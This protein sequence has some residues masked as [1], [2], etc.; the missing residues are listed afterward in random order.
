M[1]IDQLPWSTLKTEILNKP[2]LA[3]C[4]LPGLLNDVQPSRLSGHWTGCE[5]SEASEHNPRSLRAEQGA[6]WNL[7]TDYVKYVH[8]LKFLPP[9]V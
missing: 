5:E 1:T 6:G 4:L 8:D 2:L 3:L 7:M 9:E